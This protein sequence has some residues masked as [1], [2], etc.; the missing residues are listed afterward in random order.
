MDISGS[1]L[2]VNVCSLSEGFS[3]KQKRVT[4]QL[5]CRKCTQPHLSEIPP[6]KNHISPEPQEFGTVFQ[7]T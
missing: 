1:G 2:E 7:Q 3:G 5:C 6:S 4:V